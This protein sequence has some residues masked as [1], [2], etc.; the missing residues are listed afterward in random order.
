MNS[1]NGVIVVAAEAREFAGLLQGSR[2]VK[3]K[4]PL[5][6]ARALGGFI[7]LANGPGPTLSAEAVHEAAQRTRIRALVSTGLC[8]ALDPDL[9]VGDIVIADSVLDTASG[10]RY[11]A[12]MPSRANLSNIGTVLSMDRVAVTVSEKENLYR[13]T[14]ALAVEMEAA[15]IARL[16]RESDVPFYC[17]R[18]VSDTARDGL[19]MDFNGFRDRQ[20]RFSRARIAAAALRH[21]GYVLPLLHLD[22]NSRV[23]ARKLGVFLANC[24]F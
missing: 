17:I 6:F 14:R 8:G 18:A 23:A 19:G 9:T 1:N 12:A 15:A 3:L 20:G 16:A 24:R 22:R 2:G 21:P 10:E 13:S 4:W 5:D 11:A 7:L